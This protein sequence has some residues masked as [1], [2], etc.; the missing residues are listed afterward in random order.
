MSALVATVA[1]LNKKVSLMLAV[2]S[3]AVTLMLKSTVE[4]GVPLKVR[5]SASK[6]NQAGKSEPSPRVA[7]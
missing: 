7:V 2:P 4:V 3:L 5:V 1:K 6:V